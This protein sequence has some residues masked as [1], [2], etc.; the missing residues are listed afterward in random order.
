MSAASRKLRID[1]GLFLEAIGRDVDFHDTYPQSVQ[2]D[3]ETGDLLWLYDDDEHAHME[4]G[5]PPEENAARRQLVETSP[6][7][8]LEIPGLGHG[9]H[10]DMLRQFL[11]SDWTDDEV[12]RLRARQA[13]FGSIGGWKQAVDDENAIHA[14]YE[15]REQ[16][17]ESRAEQ[18]LCEHGVEA[19]WK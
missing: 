12:A 19:E 10:H 13:Y 9:D 16:A 14:F 1:N 11:N 3:L 7:R 4:A 2:L 5:V 8:Y 6:D 18:F 15:F 17:I